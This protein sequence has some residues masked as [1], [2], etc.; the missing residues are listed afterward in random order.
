M[1]NL[2]VCCFLL[3]GLAS[4]A[5]ESTGI[6]GAS[7]S[8]VSYAIG[9]LEKM[10]KMELTKIYISKLSRLNNIIIYVPFLKLEPKNPSDIKIPTTKS[11][12]SDMKKLASSLKD[13][14]ATLE[15]A[16]GGL[17][18][19]ADK[20]QIIDSILFL[21]NVINKIELIGLGVNSLGF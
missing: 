3:L 21:Q 5:Q 8:T 9:D 14:N 20:K 1:K 13:H 7:T 15:D 11:N 18:P 12:E 17:T 2:I 16:L 4:Y 10:D 6:S 19:Y